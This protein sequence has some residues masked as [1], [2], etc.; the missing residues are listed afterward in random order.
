MKKIII[1]AILIDETA[2]AYRLDC[3]GDIAWLPKSQVNFDAEKEELEA[4][5]WLLKEKFPNEEF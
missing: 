2:H 4:P 5:V 3:E 1:Q